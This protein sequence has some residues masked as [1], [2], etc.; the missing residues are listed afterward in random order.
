MVFEYTSNLTKT[1][2]KILIKLLVYT[3]VFY[4]ILNIVMALFNF[5]ILFSISKQVQDSVELHGYLPQHDY[6]A[7]KQR[8]DAMQYQSEHI[9]DV[10]S[11]IETEGYAFQ[12]LIKNLTSI[13]SDIHV[14]VYS[15]DTS[16]NV[17]NGYTEEL[18]YVGK[19]GRQHKKQQGSVLYAGIRFK[20][21]ILHPLPFINF[22]LSSSYASNMKNDILD[23][24]ENM[25]PTG[26]NGS[27]NPFDFNQT[28]N[29]ADRLTEGLTNPEGR[30]G[31]LQGGVTEIDTFALY[32]RDEVGTRGQ[33]TGSLFINPVISRLFYSDLSQESNYMDEDR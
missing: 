30:N 25:T 28:L 32:E 22:D 26:N 10:Q 13:V 33:K 29:A 31:Y 16:G 4:I 7:I 11:T 18:Y 14:V 17:D 12:G 19:S 23:T 24:I 9:D 5:P 2:I 8:I 21:R 3:V 1:V 20:Y 15:L 6:N 27:D